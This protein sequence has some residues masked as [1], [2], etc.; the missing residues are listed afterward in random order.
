MSEHGEFLDPTPTLDRD[1]PAIRAAVARVTEGAKDEVERAVRIHDFVRDRIAFGW[2][3]TFDAGRA[4]DTLARG[5]GFCN[6]KT[7]LF[8]TM[9]R[10]AG[11]PARIHFAGID[12][13]LLDPLIRPR[14]PYVDHSYAE[15]LLGGRWLHVDSYIVDPP[16]HRAAL[17][18]LRATG[19]TIGFGV[20]SRGRTRWDGR[21]DS[22]VQFVNDG[23]SPALSDADFGVHPDVPAFHATGKGRTPTSP[24]FRFLVLRPILRAANRRVQQL[25]ASAP[26]P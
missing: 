22:F 16:F 9:L 3:P 18:R 1:A 7:P 10:A 17:A 12:T 23:S 19:R 11:I 24:F 26:P 5:V 21:S 25:R 14:G 6:T 20:H 2:A 13:R 8:V 4:S 15:V